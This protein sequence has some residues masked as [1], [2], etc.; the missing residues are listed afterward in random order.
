MRFFSTSERRPIHYFPECDMTT[1]QVPTTIYSCPGGIDLCHKLDFWRVRPVEF[2][3]LRGEIISP[4]A[5]TGGTLCAPRVQ[6]QRQPGGIRATTMAERATGLG[7]V[8]R[9]GV[10]AKEKF[11]TIVE[12]APNIN[13]SGS[14]AGSTPTSSGDGSVANGEPG[15]FGYKIQEF[16][17]ASSLGSLADKVAEFVTP[18]RTPEKTPHRAVGAC[19]LVPEPPVHDASPDLAP[20]PFSPRPN[21]TPT[22]TPRS[23]SIFP[24]TT[25]DSQACCSGRAPR[26]CGGACSGG[27]SSPLVCTLR[28]WCTPRLV[29]R[30]TARSGGS[31]RRR[32]AWSS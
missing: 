16:D 27:T 26:S 19:R 17:S 10:A 23:P 1:S 21:P 25:R 5:S 15:T 12:D 14:G 28:R 11:G 31:T 18:E 20:A 22:P 3:T 32:L 24:P 29:R 2:T 30:R 6:I 9:R 7:L 8:N 13:I 4:H